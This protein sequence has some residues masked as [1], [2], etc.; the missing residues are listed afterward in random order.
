MISRWVVHS[1][2]STEP[3]INIFVMYDLN[4]KINFLFQKLII[5]KVNY[6]FFTITF[7][8]ELNIIFINVKNIFKHASGSFMN[9]TFLVL[10]RLRSICRLTTFVLI[11]FFKPPIPNRFLCR[12]MGFVALQTTNSFCQPC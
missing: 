12:D 11:C 9:P 7:H 10:K 3:A 5:L 6:F 4:S 1:G 2:T 8:N